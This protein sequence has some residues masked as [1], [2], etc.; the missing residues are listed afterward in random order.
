MTV[1]PWKPIR[2]HAYTTRISDLHIKS[3]LSETLDSVKFD[4]SLVASGTLPSTP[5]K[6]RIDIQKFDGSKLASHG[7]VDEIEVDA[8]GRGSLVLELGKE[9]IELWWPLGYGAQPLYTFE[10]TLISGEIKEE[11]KEEVVI[12]DRK[13]QKV[14]IRRAR[15]IQEPL[16]GQEGL[17]F[18]FE[19]NGVRMWIG[20]SNWCVSVFAFLPSNTDLLERERR[21][22]GAFLLF[23]PRAQN[24]QELPC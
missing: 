18:L 16:E 20:G 15:V 1:G 9:E 10:V 19:V 7:R 24:H 17:S 2:L 23:F 5:L 6:A 11:D 22:F 14:G 21:I 12:L 3:L 8:T 13:T 4:I